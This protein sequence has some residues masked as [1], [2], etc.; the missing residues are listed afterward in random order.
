MGADVTL[1]EVKAAARKEAFARRK[2]AFA[3]GQGEA[4][5]WLGEVLAPHAGKV[6]AGYMPMRTEM[7]PLPAMA[8]FPGRVCVPV[9]PGKAVPLQFRAWTVDVPMV[10]GPFG[11]RVPARGDWLVPQVLI[12]P[13]LAW[14]R[15][16]FRLGYGGGYYDRT[17][18]GLRA[19]GGCVA[20]GYGFGAQEVDAVP[21]D[22]FDQRLDAMVTERGVTWF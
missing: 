19:A 15:L 13:L 11:A 10:D 5:R 6:L 7:D 21:I 14:D 2:V 12:V 18:Q 22:G 9:V 3:A 4:A 16:G 8:G 20:V 1:D 17:I